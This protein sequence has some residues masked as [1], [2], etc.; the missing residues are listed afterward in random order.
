MINVY[1]YLSC[2]LALVRQATRS[3]TR[4]ETHE[5]AYTLTSCKFSDRVDT[6]KCFEYLTIEHQSANVILSLI[7]VTTQSLL[8]CKSTN[9]PHKAPLFKLEV[10]QR[11]Q[12]L[13]QRARRV[14]ISK[15]GVV[16]EPLGQEG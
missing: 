14:L 2:A 13:G 11:I 5:C 10:L 6:K 16:C 15:W 3:F 7:F 9:Q 1:T 8:I 12:G 4:V